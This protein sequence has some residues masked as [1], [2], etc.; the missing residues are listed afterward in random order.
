[1][2]IFAVSPARRR[3][4]WTAAVMMTS[5]CGGGMEAVSPPPPPP[6]PP[7]AGGLT[8][9]QIVVSPD[10]V[11]LPPGGQQQFIA[12]ARFNDGASG[13]VPMTWSATGGTVSDAGLYTAGALAGR[14]SVI[15]TDAVS[16][17]ADTSVVTITSV[18]VPGPYQTIAQQDWSAYADKSALAGLFGVEGGLQVQP[19]ALPVTDFYDLMPDPL[20]GKVVVYNGGPQLN[21][22]ATNMPGRVAI[23]LIDLAEPTQVTTAWWPNG[24]GKWFPTHVWVRQF[25]RFSTNWTNVS[26]TGGQGGASYK[27]MFL[28]YWNTPARHQFVIDNPRGV[29]HGG[30]NPGLTLVSEGT[31]P[32][33]NVVDMNTLYHASGWS[34]TDFYPFIKV[35]GPWPS[36]PPNAPYGDGDGEWVEIILHHKTV[37]ERG[38]FSMYWRQY[39]VNGAVD[40]QPWKIDAR[41]FIGL[42]GQTFRGLSN[43]QMGVNRNRQYDEPM[44]IYWGPYEVVDGSQ[45]PNPWSLPGG[46]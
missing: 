27:V 6:P 12:E 30:G 36:S 2:Q 10:S 46:D 11:A 19:P 3:V 7:S 5:A 13:G 45:Y 44:F 33:H 34:G 35:L 28:R 31:L 42:P 20:F 40:P 4:L 9:L 17:N 32:W 24:G 14:F 8:V 16:G 29:E 1:M 23:H 22:T 37:G 39:T 18:A 25:I 43:Y 38:E 15:A 26:V 21:I 41:Y